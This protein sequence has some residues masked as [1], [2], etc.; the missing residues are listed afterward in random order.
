VVR[1]QDGREVERGLSAYSAGDARCIMGHRSR[2]I[3]ELLGYDGRDEI[4]HRDDLVL[5]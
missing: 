1:G 3:A 2:Q 5:S 4:I